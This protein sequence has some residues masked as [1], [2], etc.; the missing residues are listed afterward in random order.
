MYSLMSFDQS[1]F[2]VQTGSPRLRNDSVHID[3]YINYNSGPVSRLIPLTVYP[4]PHTHR[5]DYLGPLSNSTDRTPARDALYSLHCDVTDVS[6]MYWTVCNLT[7]TSPSERDKGFY[8]VF[9]GNDF[10]NLTVR[11]QLDVNGSS[12]YDF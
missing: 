4:P 2:S 10:G 8:S 5:L 11:F 3:E 7:I 1:T 9:W 6:R 12:E